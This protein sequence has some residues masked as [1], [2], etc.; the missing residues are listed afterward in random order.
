MTNI[1]RDEILTNEEKMIEDRR[2]MHAHP[3]LSMKETETTKF[4]R[5]ELE[6]LGFDPV[7]IEPT[8]LMVE[9]NPE[10][11][12]K[13]VL[14]RADIDALPIAETNDFEYKSQNPGVSHACGHDIHAA[15]LLNALKAL[16]KVKDDLKGRVRIIFQP[17]E[18][19]GEGGRAVVSQ[20]LTKD[21]DSAFAIHIHTGW[22]LG[23]AATG[24]GEVMANNTFFNVEFKGKSAHSSTPHQGNDAMMMLANFINAAYGISARKIDNVFDPVVL[25][26]GVVEGGSAANAVPADIR[27]EGSFRSFSNKA[28]DFM[29]KELEKAARLSAELYDGSAEFSYNM[30]AGAVINEEKSTDLSVEI[31]KDIFGED[32][33]STDLKLSG[34]EDFGFYL[35]GYKDV[36]G[37]DGTYMFIGGRDPENSKTHPQ[38][39][40]QDFNP[41]E[42]A[43]KYGAELLAR[44]AYE[45]LNK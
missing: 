7:A 42:R 15:M 44:Y 33:V 23:K 45:Y 26:L 39:H 37:V 34:S 4:I 40:A 13:T 14:L 30:G 3:E 32:N 36:P 27:V 18:E 11:T 35:S 22:D 20:G 12:G 8:G 28:V 5:K 29:V 6:A 9:I 41:D 16:V 25:N 24:Y 43:M 10:S 2:Y 1:I 17:G 21:V 31:A 38:N 19:T